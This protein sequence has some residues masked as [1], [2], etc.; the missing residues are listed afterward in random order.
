MKMFEDDELTIIGITLTLEQE[1]HEI[2][3]DRW[4][5][6]ERILEKIRKEQGGKE[7]S[8]LKIVKDD[9]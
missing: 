1:N 8:H 6:I 2:G 7:R 9:E 5:R 4:W 3:S